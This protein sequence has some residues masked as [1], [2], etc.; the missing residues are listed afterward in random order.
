MERKY[1]ILMIPGPTYVRPEVLEAMSSAPWGHRDKEET[2]KR[3]KPIKENLKRLLYIENL[4]YEIIISSSS[5]TGLMEAAVRNLATDSE[6]ILN[7]SVGAFGE[8]WHEITVKCGK[9]ADHLTFEWG[10]S[11]DAKK[12]DEALGTGKYGL[13]TVTHNETSTGVMNSLEKISAVV[14][15]HDVLFLV[16]TVSSM[17]GVPI[18]VADLGI[19]CIVSSSQ[20]CFALPPGLAVGALSERAMKKA[21]KVKGR[22]VYFDFISFKKS[23]DKNE[24]PTTPNEALIDALNYQLNYILNAEGMEK[25]FER[26]RKLA[27]LVHRWIEKNAGLGLKLFPKKEDASVTVTCIRHEGNLDKKFIKAELI[28]RG[29]LF[30]AG[31]RKLEEMGIPT[32]RVPTMGDMSEELVAEYLGHI[33][34]LMRAKKT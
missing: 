15:K 28:K 8:L 29:Y 24:T 26:H 7:V 21:E 1:Q 30:D 3:M 5:G 13:V 11:V 20:K 27:A 19:D 34:E 6:R 4:P 33:E 16:D 2:A 23:N 18:R 12:L 32:F 25:R 17:A 31:Y 9:N 10:T 14:K 22:G